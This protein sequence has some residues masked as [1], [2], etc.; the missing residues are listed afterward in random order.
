MTDLSLLSQV[1]VG[2]ALAVLRG[3]ADGCVQCVVTSSVDKSL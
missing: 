3:L 2:D 1:L